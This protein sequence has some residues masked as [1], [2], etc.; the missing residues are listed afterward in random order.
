MAALVLPLPTFAPDE[1]TRTL[2]TDTATLESLLAAFEPAAVNTF[3]EAAVARELGELGLIPHGRDDQPDPAVT[4]PVWVHDLL[5]SLATAA[6]ALELGTLTGTDRRAVAW[7]SELTAHIVV[8]LTGPAGGVDLR[9]LTLAAAIDELADATGLDHHHDAPDSPGLDLTRPSIGLV[10]DRLASGDAPGAA[11]AVSHDRT[12][13]VAELRLLL[14]V[15]DGDGHAWRVT[16]RRRGAADED[17][18]VVV[19]A[20]TRGIWVSGPATDDAAPGLVR[21][22]RAW[23]RRRLAR[24]LT[25]LPVPLAPSPR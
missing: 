4:L 6:T 20:G 21:H 1:A 11:A 13:G 8:A 5:L 12:L 10:I 24:L 25:P 9:R 7:T 22:D 3:D 23:L 18:A 2:H 19:D 15:L 17:V 16:R 14:A